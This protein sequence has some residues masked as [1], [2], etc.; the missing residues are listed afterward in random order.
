MIVFANSSYSWIWNER[1]ENAGHSEIQSCLDKRKLD[2]KKLK[3]HISNTH[4]SKSIITPYQVSLCSYSALQGWKR[5]N[6]RREDLCCDYYV[7]AVH[8]LHP[9]LAK[10]VSLVFDYFNIKGGRLAL[11][12]PVSEVDHNNSTNIEKMTTFVGNAPSFSPIYSAMYKVWEGMAKDNIITKV[13]WRI[14]DT[15][16]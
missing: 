2:I 8:A 13:I 14:Y 4:T 6:S 7:R 3:M 5:L 10:I 9:A 1:K 12:V 15:T 11:I 16:L